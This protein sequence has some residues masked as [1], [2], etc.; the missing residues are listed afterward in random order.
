MNKDSDHNRGSY[1]RR[2]SHTAESG[3][4]TTETFWARVSFEKFVLSMEPDEIPPA[5]VGAPPAPPTESEQ[6]SSWLRAARFWRDLRRKY[7]N[8]PGV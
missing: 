3:T 4:E 6:F 8:G 5:Q 7:G 1:A 2:Q